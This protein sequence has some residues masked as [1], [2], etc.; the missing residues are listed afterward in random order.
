[1]N[2]KYVVFITLGFALVA[3]FMNLND[4][5]KAHPKTKK[6]TQATR[7]VSSNNDQKIYS[8]P[9]KPAVPVGGLQALY[10]HVQQNL[11]YPGRAIRRGIEGRVFVEFVVEKDGRISQLKILKG[12]DRECDKEALRLIRSF[13]KWKP[14]K[15]RGKTVRVKRSFPVMFKL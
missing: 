7:S 15:H 13:A 12:I 6:Q 5:A 2:I 3:G 4:N 11:K 10:N 1:M 8:V 14:G 9:E